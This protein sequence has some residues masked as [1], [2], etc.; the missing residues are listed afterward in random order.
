M[1]RKW[2]SLAVIAAMV[3]TV[4]APMPALAK[5]KAKDPALVKKVTMKR[6][7]Q[8]SKRWELSIV[9]TYSYKKAYPVQ[10]KRVSYENG[11]RDGY[12]SNEKN[13]YKFS[14]KKLPKSR[15]MTN[16]SYAPGEKPW[17]SKSTFKYNKKGLPVKRTY[18]SSGGTWKTINTYKYNKKGFMT[19][20]TYAGYDKVNGKFVL[21]E[22]GTEKY[23]VKQ[24]KGL[25]RMIRSV[26]QKGE[27]YYS[28]EKYNKKG[29]LVQEGYVSKGKTTVEYTYKYKMKKG[30]VV[31]ATRY[32]ID[33]GKKYPSR[34]W[35]FAYG[36]TKISKERYARMIDGIMGTVFLNWY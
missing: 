33:G 16:T 20:S 29:L 35:T 10:I 15:V 25:P 8:T 12:D 36:K 3:L 22:K 6:Y 5:S 23:I 17:V 13:R 1:R 26:P 4:F 2:I 34:Q 7:N 11:K 28:Y 18:I 14:K 24:K 27:S 21:N 30:R 19:S 9:S 32:Y 31:T